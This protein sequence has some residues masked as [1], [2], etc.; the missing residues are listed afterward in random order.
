MYNIQFSAN[1]M[2][3]W[4]LILRKCMKTYEKANIFNPQLQ[5]VYKNIQFSAD[6]KGAWNS[7]LRKCTKHMKNHTFSTL[8]YR[9]CMKTYSFQQTF[10]Q[11]LKARVLKG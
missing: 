6:P 9:K 10:Q 3:A 7:I 4:G 2:G 8:N 1:P 5:K 11:T